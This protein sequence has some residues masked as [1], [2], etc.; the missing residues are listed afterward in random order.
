MGVEQR[1]GLR[2]F[3]LAQCLAHQKSPRYRTFLGELPA[4]PE[5]FRP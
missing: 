5:D 3:F 1:R 2:R 4:L